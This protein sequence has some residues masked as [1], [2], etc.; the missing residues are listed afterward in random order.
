MLGRTFSRYGVAVLLAT[1]VAGCSL[2]GAKTSKPDGRAK[3]W[4][5]DSVCKRNPGQCMYKGHY[6]P[7]EREYAEQEAKRLNQ[8]SL[9]R[10]RHSSGY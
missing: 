5:Y 2:F 6:E 8:A 3:S 1:L 9:D 7:G 4:G 10:L